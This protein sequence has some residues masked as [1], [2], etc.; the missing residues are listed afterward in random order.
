MPVRR[1][2]SHISSLMVNPARVVIS[3]CC[4]D[5]EDCHTREVGGHH[6]RREAQVES[7]GSLR[8]GLAACFVAAG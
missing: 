3:C 8:A 2:L 7:E 1:R 5:R 4:A 6:H